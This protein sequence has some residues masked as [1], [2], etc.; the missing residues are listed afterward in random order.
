[1]DDVLIRLFVENAKRRRKYLGAQAVN[2][3]L[4]LLRPHSHWQVKVAH[5]EPGG[6]RLLVKL[7]T[8]QL[9]P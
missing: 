8:Y 9:H 5:V 3:S 1:M 4:R 2:G 6:C 7:T